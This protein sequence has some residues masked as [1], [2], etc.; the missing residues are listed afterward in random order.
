MSFLGVVV[1]RSC[2]T[3]HVGPLLGE[4]PAHCG[5]RDG[6]GERQHADTVEWPGRC[7][8]VPTA[9][10]PMRSSPTTGWPASS[11]PCACAS[12]SSGDRTTQMGR[13]T[14]LAAS[15]RPEGV[16]ARYPPR[17]PWRY[18]A[19]RPRNDTMLVLVRVSICWLHVALHILVREGHRRVVVKQV[20]AGLHFSWMRGRFR[21]DGLNVS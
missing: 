10:L 16:P 6:V 12:H 4:G 13:P 18:R 20:R 11:A 9:A 3:E 5:P 21:R 2:G 19:A 15:S 17:R 7:P 8:E 14:A 1:V